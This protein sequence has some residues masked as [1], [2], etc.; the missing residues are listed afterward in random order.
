MRIVLGLAG[1]LLGLGLGGTAQA[2][3]TIYYLRHGEA[4]H[5]VVADF[6]KSGI[7]TNEWPVY[8]GKGNMFTPLGET[9]VQNATTNLF[10]LK[11]D[12]IATSP[13]WRARHT[14]LPYLQATGRTAE[15]WPELIEPPG[16]T[17]DTTPVIPEPVSGIET[18]QVVVAEQ[19]YLKIRADAVC[20][21][22]LQITNWAG[23]VWLAKQTVDLL[24][25]RFGNH[26]AT[27]LLVG[28]GTAGHNLIQYLTRDPTWTGSVQNARLWMA[29]EKPD[30][31]F[32][33]RIL[34]D[35]PYPAP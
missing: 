3:L 28:H 32:E 31:S 1:L 34:N 27:V 21:C 9:Q 4:G 22:F 25:A 13:I 6:V 23:S 35:Q 12:L 30:G 20:P 7:P 5:N 8:V 29:K 19:P 11:F 24:H 16:F 26:D 14:I 18:I 33:L 10:K 2:G 15:I 17:H